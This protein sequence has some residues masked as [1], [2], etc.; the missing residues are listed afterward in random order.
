[1]GGQEPAPS[2]AALAELG[3]ST[4]QKLVG[5]L[6]KHLGF[7]LQ[8]NAKTREGTSKPDRNFSSGYSNG[9]AVRALA[10]LAKFEVAPENGT[11]V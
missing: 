3:F 11:I 9:C 4:G 1:V 8:A 5:R 6:L 10:R 2:V 7:S